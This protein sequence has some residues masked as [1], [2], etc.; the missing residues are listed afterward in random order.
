MDLASLTRSAGLVMLL[1]LGTVAQ[2]QE[3]EAI[4]RHVSDGPRAVN[5]FL[6]ET[7]SGIILVDAQGR[8]S[9]ARRIVR[10]IESLEKPLH[11]VLI[12]QA[13]PDR[14]AGLPALLESFPEAVV[15]ADEEAVREMAFDSSGLMAAAREAA[16]LDTPEFVPQPNRRFADGDVL[17]FEE[18]QFVIDQIADTGASTV[19]L[20]HL[21]QS[22][23]LFTGALLTPGVVP[24]LAAYRTGAWL[25]HLQRLSDA[26]GENRPQLFP[27]HG[28]PGPFEDLLREQI[29]E[30]LLVRYLVGSRLRAGPVTPELITEIAASY[31]RL[32][33]NR[34]AASATPGLL[35]TNI[36]AVAEELGGS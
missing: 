19:S 18:I 5:S 8:L 30:L 36:R 12:T 1:A 17:N 15:Y 20:V 13:H 27:G 9:E 34:R 21:P 35:T 32:S 11:A 7:P 14:Y 31:R 33:P 16:P 25:N 26:Y 3:P 23:R 4:Y 24:D 22:N 28:Q 2:A 29:T 6:I 10:T